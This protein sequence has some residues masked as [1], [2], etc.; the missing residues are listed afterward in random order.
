MSSPTVTTATT[1]IVAQ[2]GAQPQQPQAQGQQVWEMKRTDGKFPVDCISDCVLD[3]ILDNSYSDQ[4]YH[5]EEQVDK[6]QSSVHAEVC[7]CITKDI[8]QGLWYNCC[9]ECHKPCGTLWCLVFQVP[10]CILIGLPWYCINGKKVKK[11]FVQ[12]DRQPSD[13]KSFTEKMGELAALTSSLHTS[14]WFCFFYSNLT[15][16]FLVLFLFRFI[17]VGQEST[18][19]LLCYCFAYF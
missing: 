5:S 12:R 7:C 2:P 3:Y 15:L 9:E 10:T 6:L 17:L 14:C 4:I 18:G 1:T 11:A 16:L 13:P 8:C 19:V